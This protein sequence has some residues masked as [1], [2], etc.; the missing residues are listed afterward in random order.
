MQTAVHSSA[1]MHKRILRFQHLNRDQDQVIAQQETDIDSRHHAINQLQSVI[2]C[3]ER[4]DLEQKKIIAMQGK[5]I[6][7]LHAKMTMSQS[8]QQ[9][10][11]PATSQTPCKVVLSAM[12]AA[13]NAGGMCACMCVHICGKWA[14]HRIIAHHHGSTTAALLVCNLLMILC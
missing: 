9:R 4:S 10:P 2:A 8:E 14:V 12:Y 1:Q 6:A 13:P 3:Q 11:M 5:I 7:A